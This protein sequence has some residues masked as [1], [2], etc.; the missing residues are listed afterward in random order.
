MKSLLNVRDLEVSFHVTGGEVHAVRGVSF[1]VAEGETLAIVGESGSG[2]SVTALSLMRLLPEPPARIGKGEVIFE[3]KDLLKLPKKEWYRIRGAKIGMIFQDPMTSLN[4]T[5][6]IGGQLMEGMRWHL[7]I[8]KEEARKQAVDI[9]RK[10]GIPQPERRLSQYPHEF[11][12]G[13]RQRVMIAMAVALRPR[14]L[15]ADEPT[16]ALDVTIQAQILTLIR[17]LQKETGTSVI[18][19]THDLGVV[20]ETADR[21]AVMYGGKLVETGTVNELFREARHPYTWM[22]LMSVPRLDMPREREL[23]AIPGSPP[24]LFSPPTGCPFA[25]RCPVAMNVC[26]EE[27]PP[28]TEIGPTHRVACWLEDPEAPKH[29]FRRLAGDG[30]GGA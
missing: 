29:D 22:L 30:P 24:D 12:G 19:I 23:A 27:M 4:P 1:D 5:M 18:L 8:G 17:D 10:V 2:K 9:L 25:D 21:V 14:L 26:H 6:T 3:G 13:M 7:G 15:I 16:T 11:S 20:A 28:V